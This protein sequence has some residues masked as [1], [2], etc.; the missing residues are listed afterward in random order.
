MTTT[1]KDQ[2]I[3]SKKFKTLLDAKGQIIGERIK[4]TIHVYMG[5]KRT[6]HN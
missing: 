3:R 5:T 4:G 6:C 1:D 2:F